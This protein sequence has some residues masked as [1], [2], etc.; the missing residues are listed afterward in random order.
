MEARRWRKVSSR[1]ALVRG[2]RG[3]RDE[4][5]RLDRARL[6]MGYAGGRLKRRHYRH[7]RVWRRGD[8]DEE[9]REGAREGD[10]ID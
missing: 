4:R 2:R 6:W 3:A 9:T 10:G 5:R 1:C 8:G 7:F